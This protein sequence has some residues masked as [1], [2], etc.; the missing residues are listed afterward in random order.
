MFLI[1]LDELAHCCIS[2]LSSR[3][4]LEHCEFSHCYI[5][6]AVM[7][8]HSSMPMELEEGNATLNTF[9]LTVNI[10]PI[11]RHCEF[12]LWE[13]GVE[14][15]SFIDRYQSIQDGKISSPSKGKGVIKA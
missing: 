14:M 5:H 13:L 9:S 11:S 15:R 12:N 8:G 6:I 10:G 1:L 2:G 7:A 3:S 4:G